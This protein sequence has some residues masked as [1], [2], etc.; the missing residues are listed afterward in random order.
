MPGASEALRFAKS[1]PGTPRSHGGYG[2][3]GRYAVFL[4]TTDH[5]KLAV[6]GVCAGPTWQAQRL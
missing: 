1:A 2:G 5:Y 4:R 6:E 3:Y